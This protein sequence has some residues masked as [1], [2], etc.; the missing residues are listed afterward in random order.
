MESYVIER[1]V[2]VGREDWDREGNNDNGCD[3]EREKERQDEAREEKSRREGKRKRER[4]AVRT[5]FVKRLCSIPLM[6]RN[7]KAERRTITAY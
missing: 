1:Y 3:R 4:V 2:D 6:E 7:V 5:C